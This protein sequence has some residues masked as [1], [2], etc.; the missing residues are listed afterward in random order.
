[1]YI[2]R[3]KDEENYLMY[4]FSSIFEGDVFKNLSLHL[5]IN[6]F[7]VTTQYSDQ[8]VSCFLQAG[9]LTAYVLRGLYFGR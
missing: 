5:L 8:V 4:I 3:E 1:M 6:V 2:G 7:L 9:L